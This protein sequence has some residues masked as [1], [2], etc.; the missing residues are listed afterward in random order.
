MS[1]ELTVNDTPPL[2]M[3]I[4][5]LIVI[6]EPMVI[7]MISFDYGIYLLYNPKRER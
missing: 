6:P 1:A 3:V 5:V 7:V 4:P 2:S